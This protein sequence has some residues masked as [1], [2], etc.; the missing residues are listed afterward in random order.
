MKTAA[1]IRRAQGPRPEVRAAVPVSVSALAPVLVC[2]LLAACTPQGDP[3]IGSAFSD[4][5]ERTQ[6]GDAYKSTGG[7][8]RIENGELHVKGAKNHPLWLLR[9]LPRD[10]RVEF[11]VRSERDD[12]YT[13]T[14]YVIIF[15]GWDNSRNVLARMDEHGDDRVVGKARKVEPGETYRFRIERIGG[16]LTVWVDGDILLEMDDAEPLAGR[17]HDHFGFNNW[18]SD[19]WFDKLKVTPL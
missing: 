10:A 9:T 4:D 15:G 19:L 13:A 16:T 11:D 6:L 2:V 1:P 7:N 12:S 14:S 18:Q 8:W 5:F 17:G 3:G